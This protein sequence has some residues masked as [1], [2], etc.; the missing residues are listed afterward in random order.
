M[1]RRALTDRFCAHAKAREGEAQT[2]YFDE[3]VPGLSLRVSRTTRKAWTYH[4]TW[5]GRRKRMTLGAYPAT[6]LS[7]ARAQADTA[8]ANVEARKDP[9][10]ALSK[11]ETLTAICEEYFAREGAALRTGAFRKTTLERL[12]YPALGD[13]PI[14]DVRRSDVVRLLDA[15]EDECGPAMADQALA[16]LRRVFTWHAARSDDFRS[17]IVRGMARTKP[18]ERAR[19]RTLSDEELRT[20]WKVA[21]AQSV[22]GHFVRFIL[23]TGA[24]RNEAAEM[25]WTE[26]DKGDWT[27]PAA[28]NK[29]KVDLVRPLS[30]AA[31]AS[32][33]ERGGPFVFSTDGLAPISGFSKFKLAFDR[34]VA[35]ELRKHDPE[36]EAL[37][38]WT[39]HDL[40]R[41][42]RSLMSRA[43]VPP[44]HAERCLG[45]VIPGV[46]GV[47]DRHRYAE[48]MA[49]AYEALAAL[50]ALIVDP[51]ENVVQLKANANA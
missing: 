50:V 22:F 2:D 44:D 23:F 15:I 19:E 43:G 18:S 8:K 28:R 34:A 17:P 27:L 7:S 42:A 41:T 30:K 11:P 9:R 4:F 46:R 35:T 47:Y 20:V 49:R 25:A 16:Y 24:R 21:E 6:S 38:N 12:V 33:P 51:Q 14:N 1:P 39:L 31:I 10:S 3:A 29:T 26:I 45:H 40:R 48:E 37:A 5:G 32:L 36:R 13:R